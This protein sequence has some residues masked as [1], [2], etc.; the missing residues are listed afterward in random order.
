M[1]PQYEKTVSGQGFNR[2]QQI[3]VYRLPRGLLVCQAGRLRDLDEIESQSISR[4]ARWYACDERLRDAGSRRN[5]LEN[6]LQ[7]VHSFT[8]KAVSSFPT[9]ETRSATSV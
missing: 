1:I 6:E 5:D 2:L 4:R 7:R 3:R 8:P 9:W